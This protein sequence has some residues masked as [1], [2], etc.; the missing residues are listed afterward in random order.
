MKDGYILIHLPTQ[1]STFCCHEPKQLSWCVYIMT[2]PLNTKKKDMRSRTNIP[3]PTS[4]DAIMWTLTT[5]YSA[6]TLKAFI[7]CKTSFIK[8]GNI[9]NWH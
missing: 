9:N 1:K 5:R 4:S 2:N 3:V 7:E 8:G 6:I